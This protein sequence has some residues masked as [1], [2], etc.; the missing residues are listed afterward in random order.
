MQ[1]AVVS[2]TGLIPMDLVI[3]KSRF[4]K[5]RLWMSHKLIRL[6]YRIAGVRFQRPAKITRADKRRVK[7]A[8]RH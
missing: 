8:S 4:L 6:A 1:P 5:V 3:K 7:H 2:R